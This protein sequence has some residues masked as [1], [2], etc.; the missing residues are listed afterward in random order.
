MP[1]FPRRKAPSSGLGRRVMAKYRKRFPAR[2]IYRPG[3]G[4]ALLASTPTFTETFAQQQVV[5][6]NAGGRF[7]VNIGQIPQVGQYSQLYR[8]YRI[9]WVKVLLVPEQAGDSGDVNTLFQNNAGAIAVAGLARIVFAVNDTPGL[10]AP[11]QEADVLIDNGCKIRPIRSKWSASFKPVV[12]A[13]LVS[14]GV[15]SVGT[16]QRF[17]PWL[18]FAAAGQVDPTHYGI[19]YWI[20][21]YAPGGALQSW[22]VY[23]KVNF[24]L[25]DPK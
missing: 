10:P 6:G 4:R 1:M 21:H 17:K 5:L 2:R 19:S 20:S 8:Q 3:L 22:K 13:Q 11:A 7:S 25:R 9:N 15:A 24:S 23:Y 12:D 18:N 16:R 14:G